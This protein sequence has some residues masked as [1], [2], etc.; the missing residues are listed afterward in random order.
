VPSEGNACGCS[1][2]FTQLV[3]ERLGGNL[4]MYM[5]EHSFGHLGMESSTYYCTIALISE[6]DGEKK[7]SLMMMPHRT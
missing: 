7:L 1:I 6:V 5:L 4:I 3:V 2:I